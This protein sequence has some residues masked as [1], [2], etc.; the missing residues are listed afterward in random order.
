MSES[1]LER[2][3]AVLDIRGLTVEFSRGRHQSPLRAVNGVDLTVSPR[4]TVGL[5]GE[6]GSGKSTI[7][8]AV[9][10]LNPVAAGSVTFAGKDIT[11]ANM[12]TRRRLSNDLQVVFQDP[13][14]S[15]NPT[16]TI[17]QTLA[18][19]LRNS[20]GLTRA[21]VGDRV[22]EMLGR[23]G[24]PP[25]A[26]DRFPAQFSGGQRQRIAIARALMA[27]P[28]LV[29]CDEP[30]SALDLSVQ[31]QVLNLLR[32]LQDE[33]ELSYLFVAH[34]LA[35][36][37]YLSHRIVVLYHGQILEQGPADVVYEKPAHPY[38]RA[39]LDTA[40]VPDPH[41]QR[42]RRRSASPAPARIAGGPDSED[43]CRFVD[44]CPATSIP[45]TTS[46]ESG[47]DDIHPQGS[48]LFLGICE[49]A[50][51]FDEPVVVREVR[52]PQFAAWP[53]GGQQLL[54]QKRVIQKVA[55][56]CGARGESED[57]IG[58]IDR[59]QQCPRVV[60]P[61]SEIPQTGGQASR[62]CGWS[63]GK[64]FTE[65][66]DVCRPIDV[67]I[68]RSEPDAFTDLRQAQV[69]EDVTQ[70]SS[71]RCRTSRRSHK[72]HVPVTVPVLRNRV[73]SFH[74]ASLAEQ[75]SFGEL[76]ST[77]FAA[78]EIARGGHPGQCDPNGGFSKTDDL[79]T[80]DEFAGGESGD[81]RPE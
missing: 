41:V 29:I 17:G 51:G 68:C 52:L 20:P 57:R 6:S 75:Q 21:D 24:L 67:Q 63:R 69:A 59:G 36:V 54:R 13:Y 5:V 16:R 23:V 61:P 27:R 66:A 62:I 79:S 42:E 43:A 71:I 11:H 1:F 22:V 7:G 46:R 34:D 14:S 30:V 8:R 19:S 45:T 31:A 28:R 4:E 48:M 50:A 55:H 81:L 3:S 35:V 49:R 80:R 10:G 37:R 58:R 53:V 64:S 40:P 78:F 33:Y 65:G 25:E 76:I 26:A 56:R 18:E 74:L 47:V 15:L 60:G 77:P 73:N 32:E 9:L 72:E 2:E 12:K 70:C 39:L 44:R 38:T